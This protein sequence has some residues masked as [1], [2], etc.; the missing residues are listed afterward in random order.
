MT[1]VLSQVFMQTGSH[2]SGDKDMF[3]GA[4]SL[5]KAYIVLWAWIAL[6]T[7]MLSWAGVFTP[8]IIRAFW[9]V[10]VVA[11]IIFWYIRIRSNHFFF[12]KD[13]S[14][15]MKSFRSPSLWAVT[16]LI[17]CIGV[18]AWIYPPNN[19]DS[20]TYHMPRV[21]RWLE[22][23]NV[24]FYPAATSRQNTMPPLAGYGIAHL[25]AL[26]GGDHLA[27]FIQW[28][29]YLASI[30]SCALISRAWGV[31]LTSL[32]WTILL[33]ATLPMAILQASSTQ[34]DLVVSA[35]LLSF[36][37]FMLQ[38]R[39]N[40]SFSV[41]IWA[42]L[43]LGLAILTKGTAYVIGAGIGIGLGI[44]LVLTLHPRLTIQGSNGLRLCLVLLI[45]GTLNIGH[46]SRNFDADGNPL[47]G[48]S[49]FTCTARIHPAGIGANVLRF[50]ALHLTLPSARWNEALASGVGTVL[51]KSVDDPDTTLKD[52]RFW[53]QFRI[54]EDVMGNFI[55]GALMVMAMLTLLFS[56]KKRKISLPYLAGVGL[57]VLLF[58]L[59][60]RWQ[61]WASRLHTP[62]FFLGIPLIS[63]A[64][65]EP[66]FYLFQRVVSTALVSLGFF[67]CFHNE[68][69]PL[70]LREQR[71]SRWER[72]FTGRQGVKDE[73]RRVLD[74]IENSDASQIALVLR[75]NDW[76]YPILAYPFSR[77][78]QTLP[79]TASSPQR[80]S[81]EFL[82]S[83]DSEIKL[84]STYR[85]IY[86]GKNISL[87]VNTLT[88][89]FPIKAGIGVTE[90]KSL[91]H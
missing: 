69:R 42:G 86:P 83:T 18:A 73:Y 22:H 58:V 24:H 67:I 56:I 6:S 76:E 12:P 85:L 31:S 30:L 38:M 90:G 3:A 20:M 68:L 29:A 4:Q 41:S 7:E 87:W 8:P 35:F 11:S 28:G 74:R 39:K 82:I 17:L 32:K 5:L 9:V 44:P 77:R 13:Y 72:M 89:D 78:V 66:K 79:L 25:M 91:N 50:T 23:S 16:L 59:L 55:H 75:D 10:S 54:H 45:A 62:L 26:T 65:D 36:A 48:E 2:H 34:N 49:H 81:P 43:S 60:I 27:N 57:S 33:A 80:K 70:S 51:G 40:D 63:L 52:N 84:P 37:F 19:W 53:L 88:Q 46:W 21:V 14:P 61:P 15:G 1:L 64:T 71:S 47:S